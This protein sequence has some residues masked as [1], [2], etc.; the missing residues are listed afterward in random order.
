[1]SKTATPWNRTSLS[2]VRIRTALYIIN[3]IHR[4]SFLSYKQNN[5]LLII[6]W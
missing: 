5:S 2:F 6:T 3:V 1:M 4:D